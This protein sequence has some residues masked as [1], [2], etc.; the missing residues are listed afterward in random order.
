MV[1]ILLPCTGVMSVAF[2]VTS[3]VIPASIEFTSILNKID[4][5]PIHFVKLTRDHTQLACVTKEP[6]SKLKQLGLDPVVYPAWAVNTFERKIKAR[7]SKSFETG[8]SSSGCWVVVPAAST[9][10]DS[11]KKAYVR[12]K[13]ITDEIGRILDKHGIKTKPSIGYMANE[14]TVEGHHSFVNARPPNTE[15]DIARFAA[16]IVDLEAINV[17]ASNI[18]AEVEMAAKRIDEKKKSELANKALLESLG[19]DHIDRDHDCTGFRCLTRHQL[20]V[21]PVPGA[22]LDPEKVLKGLGISH[23]DQPKIETRPGGVLVIT[24]EI[25]SSD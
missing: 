3:G 19:I 14:V 22:T 9:E 7:A 25:D 10:L 6:P 12:V 11:F 4:H 24:Y 21:Y 1:V 13:S 18:K 17:S 23:F 2:N 15:A 5:G 8:T 20:T 16:L